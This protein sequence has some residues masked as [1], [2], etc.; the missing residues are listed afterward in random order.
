MTAWPV[1]LSAFNLLTTLN[2]RPSAAAAVVNSTN[3]SAKD[4]MFYAD[5]PYAFPADI[6]PFIKHQAAPGD[7]QAVLDAMDTF[8]GYYP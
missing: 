1:Q 8:G 2:H 7:S 5:W 4:P 6:I 3:T